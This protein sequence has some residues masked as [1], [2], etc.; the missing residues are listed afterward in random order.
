[1]PGSFA[2]HRLMLVCLAVIFIA[3]GADQP[4]T[5]AVVE[6][7]V[8]RDGFETP[9]P[10]WNR[11]QTDA[12]ITLQVH[13][14]SDRAAHEGRTSE[15]FQFSAELGSGFYFSYPLPKVP[16]TDKLKSNLY[17]R[18]NRAGIQLFARVVLPS[19]TDPQTNQPSFL[20]VPGSIYESVDRWERLEVSDLRV[21]LERQARVLRASTRRPVSLEGAYIERLVV[22]LFAG[23]GE[24]EVFLDELS[25]GPVPAELVAA[26]G[27]AGGG[28][29]EADPAEPE[30]QPAE[31]KG[32]S[33]VYFPRNRLKRRAED[34]QYRDWFFTAIHAPGAD[35][36]ALRVAGFDVLIDDIGA[37]PKRFRQAVD[38]GFLL[39]PRMGRDSGGDPIDPLTIVKAASAFPFRDAV[40]A[41]DLGDHLGRHADPA[42]RKAERDRVR[43]TISKMRT[44]PAGASRITTGIYEDD[45]ELS[46]K[47]VPK[48]GM[49]GIRPPIWAT[50]I[51]PINSY[52]FLRQRRNLTVLSNAGALFWAMLPLSA[53]P[54]VSSNVW[55]HDVPPSWGAPVIQP[56]Q[57]RWM[58]Y[59]AL[60]SGYRG[61]AFQGDADLT[62]APGRPLL[63]EMALLNAE[64]DLCE[65]I[66]ANGTDP[67][68]VYRAFDPDPPL[69]QPNSSAGQRPTK[70][71]E[72][73][74][75]MSIFCNAI[76]TRDKK[77]VLLLAAD[78]AGG[79]QFQPSQS[80]RND[81]TITVIAPE[82]AEAYEITPGR[83]TYLEHKRDVGGMRITLKEFDTTSLILVTT[84]M[85][86]KDRV[87]AVINSIR[88]RAVQLAIEQAELK[89]Q[90]V[91]EINGRLATEGHYL[92][93]EKER[94]QRRMNGGP[95]VTDEADLLA[96]AAESI[97]AARDYA[98]RLDWDNAWSEARRASRPLRILMRGHW[99]NARDA[100]ERANTPA[101]D[102]ANENLIKLNRVKKVGPPLGLQGVSSPPLASF[103]ML[104]QHYRW[105]EWMKSANFGPNLI[106]SGSFD[107]PEL[108]GEIGW[109]NVGYQVDGRDFV[110]EFIAADNNVPGKMIKI[111]TK[112]K[113]GVDIDT[114]PPFVD[115]PIAALRSPPVKVSE[116]Q[117]LRISVFARRNKPTVEGIGGVIVRDS[118]GGEALQYVSNEAMPKRTRIVLFRRVPA[119]GEMTVTLGLAGADNVF[120][121]NLEVQTVEAPPV[122]QAPDVAQRPAVRR[123]INPRTATPR[124]INDR[125]IR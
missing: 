32:T 113:S 101:Q 45:L 51:D 124:E 79:A 87:E 67:Y 78:Y 40:M 44:L 56:E 120:F 109:N 119:D 95:L 61:L 10:V 15:H 117:F 115:Y 64:I 70:K 89:Y 46:S 82:N 23:A 43:Q 62:R 105:V 102:L 110:Y 71:P 114:L 38:K 50:A 107:E 33:P 12:T 85:A 31:I 68:P 84:D 52:V 112:T 100:M 103:N 116:G 74:P 5:P 21:S 53:T 7:A 22:N 48:L 24:T 65:S 98:E 3:T 72:A 104:P 125:P 90:W 42:D 26:L 118:I 122:Y 93:Q 60:S 97:K 96:K 123:G 11:E 18:A 25:V 106:P 55:G 80:A 83:F 111:T 27:E 29:G 94:K 69:I 2:R 1:M 8:I 34:G 77:T 30:G 19:D 92:I 76:G 75:V 36:T 49:Y 81:V 58:T 73:G 28:D 66:L 91:G 37:D 4:P 88:P 57:I 20:L 6:P 54:A 99:A 39:M 9:R 41:W 16:V 13:D 63:L 108:M 35:V 121:D 17:V 59:A 86:L 47:G 14:R